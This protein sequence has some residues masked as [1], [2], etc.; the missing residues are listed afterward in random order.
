[1]KYLFLALSLCLSACL[2]GI[3]AEPDEKGCKSSSNCPG[4]LS[5]VMNYCVSSNPNTLL[6]QAQIKPAPT[7]GFVTQ[8]LSQFQVPSGH[9]LQISLLESL[10]VKGVV[11]NSGALLSSNLPGTLEFRTPGTLSGLELTQT[12]ASRDGVDEQGYG[13]TV[14]LLPGRAYT[15]S[16]RP[17]NALLPRHSAS[18]SAAEL[19]DGEA[20]LELPAYADYIKVSGRALLPD[21]QPLGNARII[22]LTEARETIFITTAES[23]RGMYEVSLPPSARSIYFK[24]ESTEQSIAF[25]DFLAGPFTISGENPQIDLFAPKTSLEVFEQ[26]IC[27][28]DSKDQPVPGRTISVASTSQDASYRRTG[29]SD[30]KGCVQFDLLANVYEVLVSSPPQSPLATYYNPSTSFTAEGETELTIHLS[31][32]APLYLSI[33]NAQGAGVSQAQVYLERHSTWREGQR[34]LEPTFSAELPLIQGRLNTAVDPGRYDIRVAPS[35]HTHAPVYIWK[36]VLITDTSELSLS[37]PE[38]SFVRMTIQTPQKQPLASSTV[39]VYVQIP[40]TQT[41]ENCIKRALIGIGTTDDLGQ[42]DFLLPTQW[43]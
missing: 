37:L 39:E 29:Q 8:Q 16:F 5:C 28:R 13:Y 38:A 3:G 9:S 23:I 15:V 18:F 43:P 33:A 36:D 41:C 19:A 31:E 42:V 20:N 17:N 24:V 27:L 30:A 25:A 7:S 1:M 34:L 26:R 32:R 4:D 2:E 10:A 12:A 22:A 6:F 11:R 21:F 40:G 35:L 14:N